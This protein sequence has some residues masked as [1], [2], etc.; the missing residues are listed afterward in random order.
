MPS[1]ARKLF[2]NNNLGRHSACQLLWED[3]C[4]EGVKEL[5]NWHELDSLFTWE[6]ADFIFRGLLVRRGLSLS[7]RSRGIRRCP[8]GQS[9]ASLTHCL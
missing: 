9:L 4:V 1:Q 6:S 3:A 5:P 8:R 2:S 7:L